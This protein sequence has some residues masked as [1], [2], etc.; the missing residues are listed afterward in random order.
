MCGPILATQQML[1]KL[2]QRITEKRD[3]L[4]CNREDFTI[5]LEPLIKLHFL[6]RPPS[7]KGLGNN[8]MWHR[9][10]GKSASTYVIVSPS[11]LL[12]DTSNLFKIT[13]IIPLNT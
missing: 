6:N 11:S 5:L 9:P 2:T 7:L 12:N 1:H 3:S 10:P 13:F 4:F 8:S